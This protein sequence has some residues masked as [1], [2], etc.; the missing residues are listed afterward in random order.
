MKKLR[1]EPLKNS[2][3]KTLLLTSAIFATVINLFCQKHEPLTKEER[4]AQIWGFFGVCIRLGSKPTLEK[5]KTIEINK[6]GDFKILHGKKN[7]KVRITLLDT[8]SL[9]RSYSYCDFLSVKRPGES[10]GSEFK[11]NTGK[12][13]DYQDFVGKSGDYEECTLKNVYGDFVSLGSYDYYQKC[14][15]QIYYVEE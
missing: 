5:G 13:S 4:L 7:I 9:K 1:D 10:D 11:C 15:Y 3:M 8:C 14:K 12:L 6:E 2:S